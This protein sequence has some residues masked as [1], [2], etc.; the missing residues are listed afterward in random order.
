MNK[1]TP[2][3][4]HP[5]SFPKNLKNSKNFFLILWYFEKIF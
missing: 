3:P 1:I 5:L 4:L 2:T